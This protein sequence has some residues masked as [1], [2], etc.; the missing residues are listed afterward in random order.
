MGQLK[1]IF[2][3][4]GGGMSLEAIPDMLNVYGQ[5]VIF[6]IGGGLFKHGPDLI[7]NCKYF[8]TIVERFV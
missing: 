8:K 7:D 1:T 2:P 6:L 4:P 5:D 3:C